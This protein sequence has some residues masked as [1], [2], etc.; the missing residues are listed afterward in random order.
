M[1]LLEKLGLGYLPNHKYRIQLGLYKCPLCFKQSTMSISKVNTQKPKCC[2]ACYMSIR[3]THEQTGSK[4]YN[5]W[6]SMKSRCYSISHKAYKN[7]GARGITVDSSWYSFEGFSEW[8]YS[9]GYVEGLSLDRIDT[10]LGYSPF[11]CRWATI[12]QQNQNTRLLRST[13]TSGFRGVFN[14]KNRPNKWRA[15]IKVNGKTINLGT[16]SDREEAARSYDNYVI[17]NNLEHPI[18]FTNDK[19]LAEID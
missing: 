6:A 9:S 4:L 7:Y 13:N 18:N 8:A 17:Q 14:D 2:R 3:T 12:F 5:V 16:F 1:L 11:N 10:N 15:I 19:T